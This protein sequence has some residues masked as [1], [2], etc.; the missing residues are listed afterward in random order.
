MNLNFVRN[1]IQEAKW[2]KSN[3][4]HRILMPNHL[5]RKLNKFL[6]LHANSIFNS[7][8]ILNSDVNSITIFILRFTSTC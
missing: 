8:F 4:N 3:Q 6:S 2:I 1:Y 5:I 7:K